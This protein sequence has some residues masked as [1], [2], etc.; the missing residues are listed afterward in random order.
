M[1]HGGNQRSTREVEPTDPSILWAWY[2]RSRT[3]RV[4]GLVG[5]GE[6]KKSLRVGV[7]SGCTFF[8]HKLD[9]G[10]AEVFAVDPRSA[11]HHP[12]RH[13]LLRYDVDTVS[14][15]QLEMQ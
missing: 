13:V 15:D 10:N 7:Q 9:L 8:R 1:K 6:K 4:S 14:K 5:F 11:T 2:A 12:L 3:S